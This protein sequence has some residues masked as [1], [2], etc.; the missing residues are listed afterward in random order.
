[1]CTACVQAK[2]KQ[3]IIKVETL[4]TTKPFELEDSN[5]GG[6]FSM[7]TSSGH[8]YYILFFDEYTCVTS[9]WVIPGKKSATCTLAYESFHARVDSMQYKVK[10]FWCDI[11]CG[12]Y[13]TNTFQLVLAA[14]GTT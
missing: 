8:H 3:K 6:P 2:H 5:V 7:P 11:G 14:C 4:G 13:N 10:Q 1:M 9:V 12:E